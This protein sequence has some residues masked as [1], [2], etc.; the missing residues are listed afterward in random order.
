ME[1]WTE[2]SVFWIY[3]KLESL[4]NQTS[5]LTDLHLKKKSKQ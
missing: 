3:S 4:L 5:I 2:S 1:K